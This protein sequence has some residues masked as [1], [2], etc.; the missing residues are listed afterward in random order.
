[1]KLIEDNLPEQWEEGDGNLLFT[2]D[3]YMY[4]I[5]SLEG[6]LWI[7]RQRTEDY[8]DGLDNWEEPSSWVDENR[9]PDFKFLGK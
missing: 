7:S 1:M 5:G 8:Y 3:G 9:P 4:N 6:T 2:H